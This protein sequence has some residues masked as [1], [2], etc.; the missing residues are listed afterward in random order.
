LVQTS[1]AFGG[2][3]GQQWFHMA[4]ASAGIFGVPAAFAAMIIVSLLTE[5]P[6]AKEKAL[7]DWLRSP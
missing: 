3:S 1:P 4:P 5:P 6:T 7:V 2:N